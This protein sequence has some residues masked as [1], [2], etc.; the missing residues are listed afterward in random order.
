MAAFSRWADVHPKRELRRVIDLH[1]RTVVPAWNR[2]FISSAWPIVPAIIRFSKTPLLFE[3]FKPRLPPDAR[4]RRPERGSLR[5]VAGIQPVGRTSSSYFGGVGRS[6]SRSSCASLRALHG[7]CGNQHTGEGIFRF[8]GC[9]PARASRHQE[10]ERLGNRRHR[11]R[12]IHRW[13]PIRLGSFFCC[14]HAAFD[15]KKRSTLD[16]MRYAA[17]WG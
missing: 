4:M 5:W 3:K 9:R 11:S 2:T 12:G 6:G 16:A 15:D 8:G 7:S 13:R 1:G 10:S 14:A 17:A